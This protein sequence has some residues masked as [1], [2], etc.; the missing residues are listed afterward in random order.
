MRLR[1]LIVT[2][3]KYSYTKSLLEAR[4]EEKIEKLA[5]SIVAVRYVF[6]CVKWKYDCVENN[7]FLVV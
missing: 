4:E 2:Y 3:Q 1:K 7:Y 6:D 5:F